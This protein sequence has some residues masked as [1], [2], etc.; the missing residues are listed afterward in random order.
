MKFQPGAHG[1]TGLA[2]E[3]WSTVG[4]LNECIGI[5]S[6]IICSASPL[7]PASRPP[8]QH[9]HA[10]LAGTLYPS[11]HPQVQR[12][13]KKSPSHSVLSGV[14]IGCDY[15]IFESPQSHKH[16]SMQ[17]SGVHLDCIHSLPY[18]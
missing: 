8:A 5:V 15:S 12:A 6:F 17:N 14:G 16:K 11:Q 13:Q 7:D 3:M 4:K 10:H 9:L 2:D 1:D 18:C